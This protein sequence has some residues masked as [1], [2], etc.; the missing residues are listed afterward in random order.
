MRLV[1]RLTCNLLCISGFAGVRFSHYSYDLIYNSLLIIFLSTL[2]FL[3]VGKNGSIL[4]SPKPR[5]ICKN[6]LEASNLF[7]Q[8]MWCDMVIVT[9]IVVCNEIYCKLNNRQEPYD[10][11]FL[12]WPA[13]Y[14]YIHE[15]Y[16][17]GGRQSGWR[18]HGPWCHAGGMMEI[19][20]WCT[21]WR[22]SARRTISYHI[23]HACDV[24][25]FYASYF[26]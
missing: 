14:I 13:C 2:W 4:E 9:K 20:P 25:P 12:L 5:K 8:G 26:A 11:V 17:N 3:F 23:I 22:S 15:I 10:C 19:I 1:P 7:L 24:N 18:R 16:C 21:R 6:K